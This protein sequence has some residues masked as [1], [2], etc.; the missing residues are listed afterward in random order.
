MFAICPTYWQIWI[1]AELSLHLTRSFM[2]S[3]GESGAR[4][5]LAADSSTL[6]SDLRLLDG[7]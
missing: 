7:D 6:P 2:G 3:A 1:Y 5:M 4:P